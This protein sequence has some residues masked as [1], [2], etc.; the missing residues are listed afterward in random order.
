[1]D[2]AQLK[3]SGRQPASTIV[4]SKPCEGSEPSQGPYL[5]QHFKC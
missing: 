5:W 2:T 3:N 1:M 4:S